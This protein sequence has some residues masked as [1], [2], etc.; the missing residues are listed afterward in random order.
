MNRRKFIKTGL[1]SLG[2]VL[3]WSI[4]TDQAFAGDG[5]EFSLKQGKR[6]CARCATAVKRILKDKEKKTELGQFFQDHSEVVF[7]VRRHRSSL[8]VA[9]NAIAVGN[10]T[11]PLASKSTA[12]VPGCTRE[13]DAEYVYKKLLEQLKKD[14]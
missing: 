3:T 8:K 6:G 11:R 1:C 12:F 9:D 13:I 5:V 10:C 2:S 4:I 7:Y 14:K